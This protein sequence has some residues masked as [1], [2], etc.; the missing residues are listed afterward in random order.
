MF[1]GIVTSKGILQAK[2]S[3]GGDSRMQFRCEDLSLESSRAGD[4]ICVSGACLTMLDPSGQQF[5][6]DVSQET[7]ALTTLGHL[8]E[9]QAVN[10]ELAL[11]AED[12]LGGHLVTG[13][14]DGLATLLSRHPDGRAERL[15]F[16]V[17]EQLARY[18]ARKGSVCLDGVSLTVNSVQGRRFSVCLIP[19]TLEITTLG[20]LGSGDRVNLEVDLVARYLERLVEPFAAANPADVAGHPVRE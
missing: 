11:R 5:S 19:H 6:A 4:S 14:V 3:M 12:R 1:T 13:H 10:L 15:E 20:S 16:E 2:T 18:V 7:L 9:G 17:P 8:Q